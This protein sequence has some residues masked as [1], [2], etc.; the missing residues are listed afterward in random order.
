MEEVTAATSTQTEG[1]EIQPEGTEETTVS[2]SASPDNK[3]IKDT[4]DE[5]FIDPKD[6]PEELQPHFKRMQRS[7]TKKMQSVNEYKTKAQMVDDFNRDPVGMMSRLATQYGYTL[8]K[9]G[10]NSQTGG[11]DTKEWQ[12]QTWNE[13]IEKATETAK[14][15]ATEEILGKLGPVFD[16]VRNVKKSKIESILD[17]EVPEWRE[18][19]DDMSELLSTHPTLANDPEKLVRLAVPKEVIEGRAMQKAL[20][21]MKDKAEAAKVGGGSSN[22]PVETK[23]K[24]KLTFAES[25]EAAK[26]QLAQG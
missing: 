18:Y 26:K 20:K 7:F 21:R 12:P 15:Q 22:Q 25:V 23:P 10:Q 24:G 2:K 14:K 9:P 6:L 4:T 13:V 11:Q 17:E 5:H 19:E 16:E 8:S 3:V 1:T